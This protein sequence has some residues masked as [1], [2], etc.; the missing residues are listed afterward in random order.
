MIIHDPVQVNVSY[1]HCYSTQQSSV[2]T[3]CFSMWL[4]L[5]SFTARIKVI[6]AA[7]GMGFMYM[8]NHHNQHEFP[9]F[10]VRYTSNTSLFNFW[11][12]PISMPWLCSK[13]L[14]TPHS[15]SIRFLIYNLVFSA[16]TISCIVIGTPVVSVHLLTPYCFSI[17]LSV[18]S[19]IGCYS[20]CSLIVSFISVFFFVTP[21]MLLKTFI[22]YACIL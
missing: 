11:H 1:C 9:L 21:A 8:N 2:K 6:Q 12:C 4:F 16:I 10:S 7:F 15:L 18:L 3:I 17:D 20:V 13:V 19:N 14:L 22:T 5:I